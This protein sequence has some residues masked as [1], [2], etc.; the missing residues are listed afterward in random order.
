VVV[1]VP[2]SCGTKTAPAAVPFGL[3][4]LPNPC[5]TFQHPVLMLAQ[6]ICTM[7]A[8]TLTCS[9]VVLSLPPLLRTFQGLVTVAEPLPFWNQVESWSAKATR[10]ALCNYYSK[11]THMVGPLH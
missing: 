11:F 4:L 8:W 3:Q 1:D 6:Y 2:G 7:V 5:E 9:Y 10:W